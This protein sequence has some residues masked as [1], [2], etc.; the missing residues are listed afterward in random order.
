VTDLNLTSSASAKVIRV[1]ERGRGLKSMEGNRA[2]AVALCCMI[3]L[4]SGDELH[5]VGAMS[6]FCRC[7]RELYPECRKNLPRFICVHG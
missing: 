5:Q 3:S 1:T 4:L 6:K 2:A 7:Y